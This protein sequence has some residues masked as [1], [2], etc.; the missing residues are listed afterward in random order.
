MLWIE[1]MHSKLEADLQLLGAIVVSLQA[2]KL[3]QRSVDVL[4]DLFDR[5]GLKL[6]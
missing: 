4:T 5:V 6:T 1:P 3:L 2:A